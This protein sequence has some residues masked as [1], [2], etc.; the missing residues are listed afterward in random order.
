[1]S[2]TKERLIMKHIGIDEMIRFVKGMIRIADPY[3][4]IYLE[5]ILKTLSH[6][7]KNVD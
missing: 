6:L 7:P 4:K 2:N 1:M 3:S 5:A